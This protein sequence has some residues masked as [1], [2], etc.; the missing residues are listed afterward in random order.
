LQN[1][2][3]V[4]SEY[5]AIIS[6]QHSAE[7]QTYDGLK[8]TAGIHGGFPFFYLMIKQAIKTFEVLKTSKVWERDK[9]PLGCFSF[10][11]GD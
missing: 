7:R 2:L 8:E 4:P 5:Q 11:P 3:Q 6:K 10:Q 9:L 1:W